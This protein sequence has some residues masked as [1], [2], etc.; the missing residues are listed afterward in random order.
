MFSKIIALCAITMASALDDVA[1]W[2]QFKMTFGKTYAAEEEAKRFE[3]FKGNNLIA[4]QL[5]AQSGGDA[6]FGVTK[7]SDL[8]KDE[9]KARYL[10]YKPSNHTGPE[11][12][13]SEI[14]SVSSNPI[15]WDWFGNLTTAV[16]DQGQ[17]GSCWAFSATEQIESMAIKANVIQ[18]S[19]PLA[20][21]QIV[22]CD[23]NQDQGCNGGDTPTA[24]AYVKRASGLEKQ[25]EFPY[26]SGADGR[27]GW[28][29]G[30]DQKAKTADI[31][32]F[33]YVGKKQEPVMQKYIQSTAPLSICVDASS[34][35]TYKKGVVGP[36]TCG[37]Q[38]DHCVQVTGYD[39]SQT[40]FSKKA[41]LVRNSWNTDWGMKGFIAV[42]YDVDACGIST[43]PTTV[44]IKV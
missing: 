22:S 24:Y 28:C 42:E 31:V 43:E 11:M 29:L 39:L 8:S 34:W 5:T 23:H 13:V 21:Q 44:T 14:P 18:G 2:K 30:R 16:K 26:F 40:K 32:G 12:D 3:I 10:T 19:E 33:K 25:S 20:V 9:F 6:E 17:C 7:Y 35:Q 38:L 36:A 41:W 1:E 37:K 15:K 4:A 27:T